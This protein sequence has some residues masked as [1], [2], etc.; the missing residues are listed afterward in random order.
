MSSFQSINDAL[1]TLSREDDSAPLLSEEEILTA[2]RTNTVSIK[3]PNNVLKYSILSISLAA[4]MVVTVLFLPQQ[5]D[6]HS[7][8]PTADVKHI[9]NPDSRSASSDEMPTPMS[10]EDQM[11]D[12]GTPQLQPILKALPLSA[13]ELSQ[14]GLDHH[15]THLTY[16]DQGFRIT[17]NTNGISVR[18]SHN[19]DA[20]FVPK[21]VTLYRHNKIFATWFDARLRTDVDRLVAVR[22]QL[23]DANNTLFPS[24]DV[25][26]WYEP[27]PEFIDALPVS[28][29]KGLLN[30]LG[31]AS[32]ADYTLLHVQSAVISEGRIFPNPANQSTATVSFKLAK[33]GITSAVLYDA[34]GNKVVDLWTSVHQSSGNV[35]MPLA[36]LDMYAN[37]MYHVVIEV[38]GIPGQVVHRL[39]IER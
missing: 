12:N 4:A 9:M 5:Q 7:Q 34:L 33:D 25:V 6:T 22:V 24:A 28:L 10:A 11:L 2:L 38:E 16:T 13:S 29:R 30:E 3:R 27:T 23:V 17:I 14:L 8:Q 19:A 37:G 39:L 21:H 15:T 35:E 31:S 18:G 26:L 32:S 36:H 1:K 20:T